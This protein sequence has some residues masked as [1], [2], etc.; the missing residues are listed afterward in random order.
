M[1]NS[2]ETVFAGARLPRALL[3]CLVIINALAAAAP[4]QAGHGN[5]QHE[6]R[7]GAQT[8]NSRQAQG[9][10]DAGG[11]ARAAT[12]AESRYG[13][14]VLKVSA[15]GG[16]AYSVRLLLPDGT[17]KSVTIDAGD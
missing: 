9:Q 7:Q 8:D 13:G 5:H 2:G 14:K 17:V 3:F 10:R 16:G 12:I 11:A 4:A 1:S 6:D 15:Q